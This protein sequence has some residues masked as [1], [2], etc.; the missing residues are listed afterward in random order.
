MRGAASVSVC[1][2]YTSMSRYR[3]AGPPCSLGDWPCSPLAAGG[4]RTVYGWSETGGQLTSV[5]AP[6]GPGQARLGRRTPAGRPLLLV[7]SPAAVCCAAPH[8][9]TADH[10]QHLCQLAVPSAG[11]RDR[12]AAPWCGG[13]TRL[14]LVLLLLGC[15]GLL[16]VSCTGQ[17]AGPWA[18]AV[19][20]A[21]ARAGIPPSAAGAV[22]A[23]AAAAAACLSRW[24]L[25]CCLILSKYRLRSAGSSGV[26]GSPTGPGQEPGACPGAACSLLSHAASQSCSPSVGARG[27][28][29]HSVCG[30]HTVKLEAF[31]RKKRINASHAA[32]EAL[33]DP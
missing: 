12:C 1:V 28:M 24:P 22:A 10:P 2:Y 21:A 13:T 16:H 11:R 20:A 17:F 25:I 5:C 32:F 18:A 3:L 19:A 15:R 31:L 30:N 33:P 23:A 26:P 8:A 14:L 9:Q 27:L 6:V 7:M 4:A 29:S